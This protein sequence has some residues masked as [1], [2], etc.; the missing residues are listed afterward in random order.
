MQI[1]V[2]KTPTITSSSIS[3]FDL[4]DTTIT[5]LHDGEVVAI[6]SKIVSLC[7][8]STVQV[9]QISKDE[10]VARESS[11]YLPPSFS[12]YGFSFTI[13]NDTLI[14]S[15]GVDE[16]NAEQEFVLWPHDAQVTCNEVR[17]HL[18]QRFGLKR[19][20]VLITDSTCHPMRRGTMGICLAHSGF[21][22][23]NDYVGKPDLFGR[24][25]R[26]TQSDVSGGIAAAAVVCMGE[27]AESTPFAV[28]S[29]LG[30]VDFQERNPTR[31]EVDLLCIS[32]EE[33]LFAPFLQAVAW[34]KG[35][36]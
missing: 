29:D 32:P 11:R 13:T 23:L 12:K 34:K 17:Q 18:C 14:P 22:A 26:V 25:M 8:G 6:T 16:S 28:V 10:L 9:D 31:A 1:R 19:V 27:G 24:P 36:K 3:L 5:D 35:G 15:A 2:L 7:E 4:L 33:D 20:G 21:A 30:F